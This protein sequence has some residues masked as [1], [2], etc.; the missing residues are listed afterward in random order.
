MEGEM[1]G[2]REGGRDTLCTR[3]CERTYSVWSI[4]ISSNASILDS[5][6]ERSS[7]TGSAGLASGCSKLY[8]K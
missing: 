7:T 1:E 5:L 8:P 6:G 4:V 3:V 2:G